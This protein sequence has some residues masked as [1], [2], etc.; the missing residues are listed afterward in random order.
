MNNLKLGLEALREASRLTEV[1]R[2][3][4]YE[5]AHRLNNVE[6]K[7]LRVTLWMR[8]YEILLSCST[9]L[10][11]HILDNMEGSR[12]QNLGKVFAEIEEYI[13]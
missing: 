9:N 1:Y 6:G 13:K 12:I 8:Y 4:I 2:E 10:I 3:G 5:T 11:A 7:E